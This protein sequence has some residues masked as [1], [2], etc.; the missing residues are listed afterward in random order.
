MRRWLAK[1]QPIYGFKLQRRRFTR[2]AVL[3]FIVFFCLPFLGFCLALD[4]IF[5]LVYARLFDTCYGIL[6]WLN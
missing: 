4:L 6:C 3:Y 2:S 1:P 5:Y